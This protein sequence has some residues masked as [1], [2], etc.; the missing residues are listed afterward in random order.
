MHEEMKDD[1]DV[2]VIGEDI[3]AYGGAYKI[4]KGFLQEFGPSRIRDTPISEIAIA[5]AAIGAALMGMKPIAEI[6]FM[7]FVAISMEQL[8]N[9]ASKMH[10]MSGGKLKV[11]LVLRTQYSL[12]RAY[13]GQH[14]E[15]LPAWFLQAPGI[16][17]VVPS[18]AY[19]AKGLLKSSVRD[20]NP[21]VF[22]ECNL[23]YGKKGPVPE[24]P[25]TIPLGQADVK[26]SGKDVSLVAISR[27]VP[28]ALTAADELK[29]KGISVEVIDPRTIQ[30]LDMKTILESVRRTRRLVV[31]S[32][33]V[34]SGGLG[35]HII[36]RVVEE[37]FYDLDAPVQNVSS[38]EIVTP[39][40]AQLEK[41]YMVN[42]DKIV[43]AVSKVVE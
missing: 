7:D 9:E 21:V 6:M 43:E 22:I 24:E 37:A 25:Y 5:G 19:D 14:T 13:G 23:L 8:I 41:Q 11:P 28:E 34:R 32:D 16:K 36:S 15:F 4:T 29:T 42:K 35:A 2:I 12:G 10:F 31:A 1:Q 38:P 30:P 27:L 33:D 26:V 39:F 20:G 18:T 3:G 40:S 17:V